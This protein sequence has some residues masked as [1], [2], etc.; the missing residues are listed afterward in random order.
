MSGTLRLRGAISGYSE[1]Q[2]A[3]VAGDQTF[4]LPTA[5]GTLLTTDSP[6]PELT[7]QLGS[8]SAPS[9]RFEGDTDTG[10]YSQGA[11]TLN[12]VTGGSSKVVLGADAHTIY[13]GTGASV[14]AIDIDSSGNVGIG[15]TSPNNP[16][17]IYFQSSSAWTS[18]ESLSNATT[19]NNI[20]GLRLWNASS[21]ANAEASLLLMSGGSG[22][23]QHSINVVKRG[24]NVGDLV[25][26]RRTGG[27]SSAESARIDSNGRLLVGTS[28]AL[29]TGDSLKLHLLDTAG[30]KIGIGRNDTTTTADNTIGDITFYGNDS[31]GT[32]EGCARIR[33]RADAAHGT[34]NKPSRLEFSTTASSASSPTERMRIDSAGNVGIGTTAPSKKLQVDSAD[35]DTALFKRTNSTGSASIFLS[36]TS[37]HGGVVQSL[38]NGSGGLKF[39]T[40]NSGVLSDAV[41]IDSSGNV[42]IGTTSPSF[43]NGSG[44][45]IERDGISTLRIEDSSGLGAVV[46]IFADDGVKSAIY[47]SRGNSSNHG[48]EFR[49]NGLP[50]V[51]IDSSGRLL[52]GTSSSSQV[53]TLHLQ[54]HSNNSSFQGILALSVGSTSPSNGESIGDISFSD[55]NHD[56]AALIRCA[57]DGGTWTSNSSQPTRLTFSTTADGASSPTERMRIH[58]AGTISTARGLT[59]GDINGNTAS[60]TRFYIDGSALATGVGT[61]TLKW[62]SSTGQVTQDSSSRLVKEQISDCAYGLEEIKL[63][64][65]RKYFRSDSQVEEIGFI[66]DEVAAVMPEFVPIGSKSVI[67]G[68][69]ED[70]EEVPLSVN[71]DKMTAV[72]TAALQ[73][74]IAKIETLEAKVAALEAG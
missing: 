15:T 8:A 33:C 68:N 11:N 51:N 42:G 43:S 14:R 26:R 73:E 34:G 69:S 41:S 60:P 1:L 56:V 55:S 39:I 46:E 9:L 44:L 74:A 23:A 6:V 27:A 2:A 64:Q 59:I 22:S 57:R 54:G 62:N 25:F 47:D 35:F 17:E 45:E 7:L 24:T 53:C 71:Y 58:S 31:N 13:A 49:V 72:L 21:A 36:N 48:H 38:G 30:A 16:L 65:P 63:L 67:T 32:Y 10:L 19:N 61:H 37:D 28:A 5:G 66:A 4:I 29:T 52:V 12:L 18:G 40:Q 70:T 20:N 3:P 50:K